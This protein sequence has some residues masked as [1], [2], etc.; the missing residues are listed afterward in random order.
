MKVTKI[1]IRTLEHPTG[2]LCSELKRGIG[3]ELGKEITSPAETFSTRSVRV[4]FDQPED[5]GQVIS[6][7]EFLVG[8]DSLMSLEYEDGRTVAPEHVEN[9]VEKFWLDFKA[10]CSTPKIT[11]AELLYKA[12]AET[13]SERKLQIAE[14]ADEILA[15]DGVV[16]GSLSVDTVKVL[17]TEPSSIMSTHIR[18][19]GVMC[20]DSLTADLTVSFDSAKEL[21]EAAG[22][23]DCEVLSFSAGE[24]K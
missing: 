1:V 23:L 21:Y 19:T 13:D 11:R 12:K 7:V 15:T 4:S 20:S 10:T 24:P 17:K 8:L 9:D 3:N 14:K 6:T 2:R 22:K 5:A 18:K 16:G